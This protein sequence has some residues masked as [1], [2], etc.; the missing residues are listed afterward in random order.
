MNAS[1]LEKLITTRRLPVT[2]FYNM[3]DV[4]AIN[5]FIV[6]LVLSGENSS[7]DIR[8]RRAF[9]IQLGKKLAGIKVQ[10]GFSHLASSAVRASSQKRKLTAD[11]S[12]RPKKV[13]CHI[14]KISRDK[15]PRSACCLCKNSVCVQQSKVIC[16]K[17]G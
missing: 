3:I 14:C 5:A 8:K 4:S 6:W 1:S 7:A 11:N 16:E 10:A 17:C 12:P 15:K 2:L 13:R 9:L